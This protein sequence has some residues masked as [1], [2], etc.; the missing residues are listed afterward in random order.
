MRYNKINKKKRRI[1]D[2]QKKDCSSSRHSSPPDPSTRYSLNFAGGGDF[3][4]LNTNPSTAVEGNWINYLKQPQGSGTEDDPY[5]VTSGEELAW[6]NN[7]EANVYYHIS[8]ENDI[9]L[10][11]HYWNPLYSSANAGKLIINGNNNDILNLKELVCKNLFGTGI[12]KKEINSGEM[13]K[14]H[15]KQDL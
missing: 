8:I 10:S 3:H 7:M 9:D 2:S 11:Y 1:Y 13:I 5:R 4:S 6:F 15:I 12:V 14:N